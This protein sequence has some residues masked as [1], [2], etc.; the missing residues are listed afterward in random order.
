MQLALKPLVVSRIRSA[1]GALTGSLT[2]AHRNGV[3]V[4]LWVGGGY[5]GS[6]LS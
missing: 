1:D 3:A 6:R 5:L 4:K 2:K